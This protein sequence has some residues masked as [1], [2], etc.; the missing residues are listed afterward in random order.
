MG[1]VDECANP[2]DRSLIKC[3]YRHTNVIIR[4]HGGTELV[5]RPG[6]GGLQGDTSMAPMFSAAY[7]TGMRSWEEHCRAEVR[8]G[9]WAC[10]PISGEQVQVGKTL[11]A[12]DAQETNVT[13]TVDELN[14]VLHVSNGFLNKE[15]KSRGLG[16]NDGTDEHLVQFMGRGAVKKMQASRKT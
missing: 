15:L 11:Y 8:D 10:D 12:D 3:R 16:R 5:V 6:C 14:G 4:G 2:G 7:D 13:E 9:L 1:M